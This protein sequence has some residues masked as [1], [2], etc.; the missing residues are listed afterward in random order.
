MNRK[1]NFSIVMT[2]L[3]S[4]TLLFSLAACGGKGNSA[5]DKSNALDGPEE[6]ISVY[7]ANCVS[8]HGT[9]LQ[10]RVGPATNLQKVG[11]RMSA[12]DITKQ[13]EQGEGSMPA[14]KERLTAEEIA[15]LSDWLASKK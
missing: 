7:K 3:F 13:I 8:C 2:C 15:G 9:G 11:E 4:V 14:F 6:V 12:S 10:G 1:C 5:T